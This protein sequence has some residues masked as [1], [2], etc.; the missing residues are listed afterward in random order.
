MHMQNKKMR[1]DAVVAHLNWDELGCAQPEANDIV[2]VGERLANFGI[3]ER[4]RLDDRFLDVVRLFGKFDS[5]Y[6]C[7]L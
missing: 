5:V 4:G 3:G 7:S 6:A 2:H 1:A